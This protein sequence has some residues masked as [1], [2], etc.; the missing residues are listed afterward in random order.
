M[1]L[2]IWQWNVIKI[3]N[4]KLKKVDEVKFLGIIF[5]DK[6]NWEPNID[7]LAQKLNSSIFMNY[8]YTYYE[9]YLKLRIQ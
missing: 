1:S 9:I 7:H 5:D 6:L 2:W 4:Q 3:G 8:D